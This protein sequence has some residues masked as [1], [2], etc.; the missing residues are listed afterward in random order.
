MYEMKAQTLMSRNELRAYRYSR[1][2]QRRRHLR[3]TMTLICVDI[4]CAVIVLAKIVS[5]VMA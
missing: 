5:L 4:L 3:R 2:C 1:K